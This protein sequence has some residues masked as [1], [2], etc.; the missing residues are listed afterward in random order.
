MRS[1]YAEAKPYTLPESLAKLAG[2]AKDT[3]QLT[4]HLDWGPRYLYDLADEADVL[5]MYQP[6]IR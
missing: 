3:V 5:M 6:V 4:P 1:R 2:A